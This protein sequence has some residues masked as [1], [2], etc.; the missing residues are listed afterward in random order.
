M[1]KGD[2][3]PNLPP[4]P[5]PQDPIIEDNPPQLQKCWIFNPVEISLVAKNLNDGDKA[6]GA[7]LNGRVHVTSE[8]G[9]VGYVPKTEAEE[10][11]NLSKGKSKSLIGQIL[12]VEDDI[13]L[14]E[15]CLI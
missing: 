15:L 1:S 12:S 5:S 10:M 11:I 14:I 2:K 13:P 7:F 3:P 9:A 4:P 6:F 8:K